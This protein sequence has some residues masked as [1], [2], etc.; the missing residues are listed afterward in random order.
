MDEIYRICAECRLL[1]NCHGAGKPTGE[2]RTYPHVINREA[3]RGEEFY[4]KHFVNES[5][6]WAFTRNVV[7]P[8]DITPRVY[9]YGSDNTF[10]MQLASC[11]ILEAGT[12]CMAGTS[13]QYRNFNAASFYQ[14]LPA[15]WDD[16]VFLNG[17]VGDF[18]TI[19]RRSGEDWYAASVT[20][21]AKPGMKM[22]LSFLGDGAYEAV[23][24]SDKTP[25]RLNITSQTVYADDEL[26]YDMLKNG[27]YVVK[28]TKKS[29]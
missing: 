6:I 15:A 27:G 4:L 23:I 14:N 26:S 19:A 20:E 25:T 12:P 18:V 29:S 3:V 11:V 22:P 5:V 28:F 8:M 17:N 10:A 24:Y 2:R 9:P 7:G 16:T 21:N 1:V 13:L